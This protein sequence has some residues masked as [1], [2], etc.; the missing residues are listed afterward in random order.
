MTTAPWWQRGAVYQVYP[1]SFADADGDGVGDLEGI[2]SR[3]DHLAELRVEALWLSPIFPSPMADFG[4][5]VSDYCDVDPLFG[6]LADLDRL[7]ADCHARGIRVVLD[8]VPNHTSDRHPWF[9]ESRVGPRRTRSATGTSGATRR[10]A[11]GRRTTGSPRSRAVGP[12]WT[13]DEATGQYYLH[14][15]MP[16]QPDLDWDNPEVE[17]AMHDVLRFWLDRGRRRLPPRRDRQDRQGPAAA[18]QPRRGASATTRT[19]T[20]STSACAGS[21]AWSTP[22]TTA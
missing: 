8:W 3:L 10:P 9:V 12:A 1:R 16:E 6:T 7:I 14:S 13:L 2:R 17:A 4:Y 19:G 15:F 22:T 18:R 20:R 11:A 5:D 21:A